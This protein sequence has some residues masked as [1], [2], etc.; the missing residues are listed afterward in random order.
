MQTIIQTIWIMVPYLLAVVLTSQLPLYLYKRFKDKSYALMM[1][2][3]FYTG[4]LILSQIYAT[5]LIILFN[6]NVTAG[7][8]VYALTFSLDNINLMLFGRR[9]AYSIVLIAFS[10]MFIFLLHNLTVM[11]LPALTTSDLNSIIAPVFRITL[12]SLISFLISSMLDITL[13]NYLLTKIKRFKLYYKNLFTIIPVI[14]IDTLL[15][16]MIAFYGTVSLAILIS[17]IVGQLIIKYVI[18]ILLI[19]VIYEARGVANAT[20][21]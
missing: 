18:N 3:G 4:S 7:V 21:I 14:I 16:V 10:F 12:G 19:P 2:A 17:L 13:M 6:I 20:K 1:S 5:K 15:F 11:E 9:K 8:L